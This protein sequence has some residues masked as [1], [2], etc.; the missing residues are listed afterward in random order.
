[1]N[2]PYPSVFIE[3]Y[4]PLELLNQQVYYEH[5]R[6][7][8]KGLHRWYSR[9][10][11]SLSRASVLASILPSDITPE[12]FEILLGMDDNVRLYKTP[13]SND[14]IERVKDYCEKTW[15]TRSPTILDAFGGGG[16]IPFEAA[17]YKLNV[18]ASDL[19]PVAVLTMKAAIEYPLKLGPE[20][21]QHID[22][23]VEWVGVEAEKRLSQFFPSLP[24][25]SI[26]NYL[27]AHTVK[28]PSCSTEVPLSPNWW[29]Y[30]RLERQ[31]HHKWTAVKLVPNP[32]NKKVDFEL[33]KGHKGNGTTIK[34][35]NIEFDP[36]DYNTIKRG[37]GRCP[38]CGSKIKDNI[39]KAQ[40][41][42]EGLG[43]QLYAV[44]FRKNGNSLEFR[45][46]EKIDFEGWQKSKDYF[47]SKLV[48]LKEKCLVPD[49]E[50]P[51]IHLSHEK[52][53]ELLEAK[54]HPGEQPNQILNYG[55]NK[56]TD[57]FNFRQLLTLI[58]Y[59]EIIQEVKELLRKD[60]SD[61]EVDAIAT[62]LTLVLDRCVDKNS[63]LS[64]LNSS[65]GSVEQSAAHHS[66]NMFWSYP[67][68]EAKDLWDNCLK[69]VTKDYTKLNNILQSY[70]QKIKSNNIIDI[71]SASAD[72]LTH[73]P[74]KSVEV[75]VTDPPYYD[76]IQYAELSDFY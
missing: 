8:F 36:S 44:A 6:N 10:P 65:T 59:T 42:S 75:I 72:N 28:C 19:N 53:T 33:I 14:I 70:T 22:K 54:I 20:L 31:N 51:Y 73:I 16:S 76:T 15:G 34:L 67:E 57:M 32:K 4:L 9:K 68:T 64:H 52:F 23:W 46:P 61:D 71:R 62:Y 21:Q 56:W 18:L 55:I 58:T 12:E 49:V 30:K 2:N 27:W 29:L 17:R 24:G 3:K 43:H 50:L 26:Q 1:M 74:D 41:K 60:Y 40:A 25:E 66:L 47:S 35:D 37:V 13:P 38:N 7:P 45:L 63:R 39:I 48:E 69:D 5:G 11:L